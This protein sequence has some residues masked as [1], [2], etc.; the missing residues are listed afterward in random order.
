VNAT[1]AASARIDTDVHCAPA[2]LTELLEHM[3]PYWREYATD[4]HL[5]LSVSLAGAY[6][7]GAPVAA[8]PEARQDGAGPPSDVAALR[9]RLLDPYGLDHAVLNCLTAFDVSRNPYYEA[10]LARAVNE[11]VRTRMLE[12]DPRLRASIAVPTQD[13]EAAAAEIARLGPDPRFVQVLLPVRGQDNRYGHLRY[14][15][16]L[17]AAAEHGLAVCLHAWGRAASSP[18]Y[19]GALHTYAEDYLANTQIVQGQVVSLIAEGVF[20]ELPDLRVCLAECGFSWVPS[21]LWRFDKEW[22]GVWREVPWVKA[23][24]SEYFYRHFRVTTQPAHLPRDTAQAAETLEMLR[25]GDL[26]MHASDHPHDHGDGAR[27]LYAALDARAAE[28]VR[29]TNAAEF[30]ALAP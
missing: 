11:W 15:P 30:Y 22:K 6:P 1:T 21:L 23:R 5:A 14:R 28:A 25:A 7:P 18:T 2:A 19:T 9:H 16:I 12:E 29:H 10:E 26:L 20:D 3:D 8:T 24:P 4:A 27:R 17:R 13:P